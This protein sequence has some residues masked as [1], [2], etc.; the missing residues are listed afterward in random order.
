M[1]FSLARTYAKQDLIDEALDALEAAVREAGIEDLRLDL[2]DQGRVTLE[3]SFD[4]TFME[5]LQRVR[6]TSRDK[7]AGLWR[8]RPRGLLGLIDLVESLS[9]PLCSS[10]G[11]ALGSDLPPSRGHL[12]AHRLACE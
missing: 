3:R 8:V 10:R 11:C 7:A 4:P 6:G 5:R 9:R 1:S 12:D 2:D